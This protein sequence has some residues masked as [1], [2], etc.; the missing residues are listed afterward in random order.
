MT[1]D[2]AIKPLI[3]EIQANREKANCLGGYIRFRTFNHF[4]GSRSHLM[5]TRFRAFGYNDI[6]LLTGLA[7]SA[8]V[9]ELYYRNIPLS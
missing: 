3:R 2:I 7:G 5:D 8:A 1:A 6:L 4:R 9:L